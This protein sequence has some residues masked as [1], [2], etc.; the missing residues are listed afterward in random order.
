MPV[1]LALF[2]RVA[3]ALL[4]VAAVAIPSSF[5]LSALDIE[6]ATLVVAAEIEMA[7]V[8]PPD[9][10]IGAVPVT[11]VTGAVPLLAAVSLPAASTVND[12]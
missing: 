2:S 12:P 5:V 10:T 8:A 6:P 11:L 3:S 7:G 1:W 4:A 9:E